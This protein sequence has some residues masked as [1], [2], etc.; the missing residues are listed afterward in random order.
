MALVLSVHKQKLVAEK[1]KD[2]GTE[3]KDSNFEMEI[4]REKFG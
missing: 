1:L 2:K 4:F 3:L